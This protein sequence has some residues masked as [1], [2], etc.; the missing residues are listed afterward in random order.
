MGFLPTSLTLS[1]SIDE[2]GVVWL[3]SVVQ[4]TQWIRLRHV[5]NNTRHRFPQSVFLQ[6]DISICWQPY[7]CLWW[8]MFSHHHSNSSTHGLLFS[9]LIM[10]H[11]ACSILHLGVMGSVWHHFKSG[12]YCIPTEHWTLFYCA[13]PSGTVYSRNKSPYMLWCRP[14]LRI[15]LCENTF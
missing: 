3:L 12:L 15:I 9:H 14:L 1:F 7:L 13:A 6:F 10:A 2:S 4:C 8:F 11:I 5:Q